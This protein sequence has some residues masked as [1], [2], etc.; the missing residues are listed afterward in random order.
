MDS[1]SLIYTEEDLIEKCIKGNVHAQKSLY[2]RF[3]PKLFAIACR[4]SSNKEDAKDV[5]QESFIK[6]FSSLHTFKKNGSFEGWLKRIVV[7][8]ALS[9]YRNNQKSIID[10]S[11]DVNELD[12]SEEDE[13]QNDTN[14]LM[15]LDE[16]TILIHIQ[17][18]PEE[19][20]LVFNLA[21]IEGLSHKEISTVLG[22]KEEISRIRLL[23]AR[24]KLVTTLSLI[25]TIS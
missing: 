2:K 12:A 19:F 18:L 11:T 13:T 16:Q 24:K 15:Q 7:N 25:N 20:R 10:Y 6:I 14:S 9:K 8:T 17:A 3:L 5:M 1:E 21:C 4:Y 23:R 22:I